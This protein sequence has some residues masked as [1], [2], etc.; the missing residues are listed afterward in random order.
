MLNE[1]GNRF[2]FKDLGRPKLILG[3]EIEH[4]NLGVKLH[5]KT[6]IAAMLHRYQ[7]DNCNGRLTPLNANYFPPR[8][9]EP[10][11]I[12]RQKHYQSIVGSINF[13]A[14]I[15]RPDISYT[16]RQP[17]IIQIFSDASYAS[18]PDTTKSFSGYVLKVNGS[19]MSWSSKR[20]SYVA[21]STYKAKYIAASYAASHLV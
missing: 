7:I 21:R 4:N 1:T 5:Q 15:S 16:R 3:L 12:G 20:Q 11:N 17:P 18:D 6:Y 14:I 10:V 8:S 13:L 19:A 9:S 2:K